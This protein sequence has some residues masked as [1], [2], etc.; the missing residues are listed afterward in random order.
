MGNSFEDMAEAKSIGFYIKET[1]AL[2][3]IIKTLDEP[4]CHWFGAEN[5]YTFLVWFFVYLSLQW[6]VIS[7]SF[8]L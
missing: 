2:K 1:L 8:M 5:V 6:W 7:S 4:K 3:G